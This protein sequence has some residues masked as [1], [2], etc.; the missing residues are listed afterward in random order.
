MK[1]MWMFWG[2]VVVKIS[3]SQSQKSSLK[4]DW[5]Y[6]FRQLGTPVGPC[7]RIGLYTGGG[8]PHGRF[9]TN[10]KHVKGV[11]ETIEAIYE[12]DGRMVPGVEYGFTRQAILMAKGASLDR[13][14]QGLPSSFVNEHQ[15]I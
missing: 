9:P 13:L 10:M 4:D 1:A 14:L 5:N 15:Y 8:L 12:M 2:V 7:Q 3:I 6:D 11:R